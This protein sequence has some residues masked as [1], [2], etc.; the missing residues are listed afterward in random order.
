M[1]NRTRQGVH[2]E[3]GKVLLTFLHELRWQAYD[4]VIIECVPQLDMAFV[5]RHIG[6]LYEVSSIRWGPENSGWPA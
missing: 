5:L 2:G 1:F 3:S 4:V 6:H